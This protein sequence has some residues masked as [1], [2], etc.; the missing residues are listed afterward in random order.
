ML[1]VIKNLSKDTVISSNCGTANTFIRR[2]LG[3]MGK[4]GLSHGQG[5]IITPCNSIHMFF[6]KFPIDAIFI[7]KNN[8]VLL[9]LENFKPWHI[10]RIVFNA[11]SVIELPTGTIKATNTS[12][13]DILQL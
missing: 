10:S 4:A 6:M 7:D 11:Y 5:L 1:M 8:K 13:N 9:V 2:F 3:L 12:I